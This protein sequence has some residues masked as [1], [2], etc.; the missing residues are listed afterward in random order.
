MHH[1]EDVV[2]E[3]EP[4]NSGK[5]VSSWDEELK[6][7]AFQKKAVSRLRPGEVL[8]LAIAFFAEVTEPAAPAVR[9]RSS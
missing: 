6:R 1:G 4:G 2:M 7:T 5:A 3:S 9:T 8:D